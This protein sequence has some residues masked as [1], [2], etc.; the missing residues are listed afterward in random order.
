MTRIKYLYKSRQTH[1]LRFIGQLTHHQLLVSG[2][3]VTNNSGQTLSEILV[4]FSRG[5]RLF[6]YCIIMYDLT[7]S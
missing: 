6:H 3:L 1:Y 5:I 2:T 7:F 4:Q